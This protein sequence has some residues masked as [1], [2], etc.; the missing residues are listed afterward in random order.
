MMGWN[1][2]FDLLTL[3]FLKITRKDGA[4]IHGREV[5]KARVW[6]DLI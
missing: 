5:L 1:V 2:L 3:H 4:F 6:G